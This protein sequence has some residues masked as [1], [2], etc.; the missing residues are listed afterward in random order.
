MTASG[1]KFYHQ[2]ISLSEPPTYLDL[3]CGTGDIMLQISEESFAP[4]FN[5]AD[6][7]IEWIKISGPGAGKKTIKKYRE[8][9]FILFLKN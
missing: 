6:K 7:L 3:D 5:S 1:Y 9:S 8:S 4:G 2:K